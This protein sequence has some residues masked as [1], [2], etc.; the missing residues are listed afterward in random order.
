M[1][2]IIRFRRYIFESGMLAPGYDFFRC[3]VNIPD[4]VL[5]VDEPIEGELSMMTSGAMGKLY[6]ATGLV[7]KDEMNGRV[8]P[9]L[10][11]DDD[12][13]ITEIE[14]I[15]AEAGKRRSTLGSSGGAIKMDTFPD[16]GENASKTQG[17]T[18]V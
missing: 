15:K 14:K 18:A 16:Q 11:P 12:L 8:N 17:N 4:D 13:D 5:R 1:S 7:G 2:F 6:G 9:G 3:V 10:E